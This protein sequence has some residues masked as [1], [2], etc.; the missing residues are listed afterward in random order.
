MAKIKKE[1]ADFSF[2]PKVYVINPDN[3]LVGVFSLHELLLQDPDVPIYRFMSQNPIVIHL[4]TPIEIVLKKML[5]Y[6]LSSLPVVNKNKR[7]VGAITSDDISEYM[8][9]QLNWLQ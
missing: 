5:K 2:L 6:K 1:T 4:T 8:L 3:Q 9:D 7:I